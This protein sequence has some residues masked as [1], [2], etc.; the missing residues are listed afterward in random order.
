MKYSYEEGATLSINMQ[1]TLLSSTNPDS[2]I[3][4]DIIVYECGWESNDSGGR[5]FPAFD[6]VTFAGKDIWVKDNNSND[7]VPDY[8]L[9]YEKYESLNSEIFG[10]V[11]E[12]EYLQA[13][14][15]GGSSIKWDYDGNILF[16]NR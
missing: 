10:W 13:F 3:S 11:I 12:E 4:T 5:D 1:R 2:P 14:F 7:P 6:K 16:D 15:H 8:V 9:V